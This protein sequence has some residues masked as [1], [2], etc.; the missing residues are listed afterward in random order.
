[1]LG[2]TYIVLCKEIR[3]F[4]IYIQL[5]FFSIFAFNHAIDATCMCKGGQKQNISCA[6]TDIIWP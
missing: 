3:N 4:Q 5:L 1:M 2:R 6:V